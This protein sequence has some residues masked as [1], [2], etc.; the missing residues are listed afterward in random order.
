MLLLCCGWPIR[1]DKA[2]HDVMP[3]NYGYIWTALDLQKPPVWEFCLRRVKIVCWKWCNEWY[4]DK[5]CMWKLERHKLQTQCTGLVG[6]WLTWSVYNDW[7]W[8][9][10]WAGLRRGSVLNERRRRD[11]PFSVCNFILWNFPLL[12]F[13]SEKLQRDRG[14]RRSVIMGNVMPEC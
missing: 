5:K 11:L 9:W 2:T 8:V 10:K 12:L 13:L 14:R 1:S 6:K 4:F 7:E 3:H